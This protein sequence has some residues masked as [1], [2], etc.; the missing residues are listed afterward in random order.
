MSEKSKAI[1]EV[2]D[3]MDYVEEIGEDQ[4]KLGS[5]FADLKIDPQT[6]WNAVMMTAKA[7]NVAIP[8]FAVEVVNNLFKL[9]IRIGYQAAMKREMEKTFGVSDNAPEEK[10]N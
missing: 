1:K 2:I 3:L 10:D 9:G 4:P 6:A 7:A 8:E 5:I